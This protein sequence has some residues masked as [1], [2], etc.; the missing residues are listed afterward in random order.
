VFFLVSHMPGRLLPT[1]RSRCRMLRFTALPDADV[2]AILSA[3]QGVEAG[4]VSAMVAMAQGSPGRALDHADLDMAAIEALLEKILR[5]GD[6]SNTRRVALGKAV[7]GASE[8]PRLAAMLALAGAMAERTARDTRGDAGGALALV[9]RVRE[10]AR[11]ALSGSEDGATV[12]FN[13]GSAFA[14][15]HLAARVAA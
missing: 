10:V 7:A 8:R 12:G 6:R 11:Y 5:D 3:E 13:I 9:E 1:I 4:H 2:A 15:Y 14:D